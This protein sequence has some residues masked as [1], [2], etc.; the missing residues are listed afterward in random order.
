MIYPELLS[1]V[2]NFTAGVGISSFINI[3]RTKMVYICKIIVAEP[4]SQAAAIFSLWRQSR[5]RIKKNL[6]LILH[7]TV[8]HLPISDE[9][10]HLCR[11]YG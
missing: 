7:H 6:F 5:C 3:T 2:R 8:C 9:T 4:E 1:L 11:L 10:A